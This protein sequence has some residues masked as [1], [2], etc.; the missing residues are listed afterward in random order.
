MLKSNYC[1]IELIG[2]KLNDVILSNHKVYG[3]G[4]KSFVLSMI[5]S[6]TELTNGCIKGSEVQKILEFGREMLSAPLELLDGVMETITALAESHPLMIITKGD[7]FDQEIKIAC[8]GIA[9]YFKHIEIVS[10]K[11]SN[12][13]QSI[14]AKYEIEPSHFVMVGNSL[15]SDVLPVVEIGGAG[16]HIPYLVTAFHETVPE[17][18]IENINY[19]ELEHISQLPSLIEVLKFDC[20][21]SKKK[22]TRDEL[23]ER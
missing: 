19:H 14:L 10:S 12:I 7:L 5:E 8:S 3:Y 17:S 23:N 4:I 2:K 15:K 13:Y 18:E 1:S 22:F 9:D 20:A 6:A 16:V 11:D 21:V